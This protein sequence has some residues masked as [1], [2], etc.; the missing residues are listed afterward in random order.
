MSVALEFERVAKLGSAGNLL[1][2]QIRKVLADLMV[3]AGGEETLRA[4][5]INNFF[6]E[7]ITSKVARK[8]KGTSTRYGVIV[9]DFLASLGNQTVKPLTSLSAGDVER[10]L[11]YRTDMGLAPKT[12]VMDIKVIGSALNYARRQGIIT[13][14][15]AEALELPKGK[16]MERGTFT[17]VEVKLLIDAAVGEWKTL[18]LL[19]YFTGARLSDCCRMGWTDVD[20]GESM[21]T[22]TQSK[23]GE[24]VTM[25]IHEDL[26]AH[27]NK[28][29]ST[30]K[31]EEFLM[32]HTANLKSGGRKGLSETFKLI[33]RDAGLDAGKVKMVGVRQLS[34]RSF[35]ALR[36]SFNSAMA[37]A[38]VS[39]EVRMKLTGHKTESMNR[40]YT[41]HELEPLRNAI[42]KIPS[43]G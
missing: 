10:F 30:D 31:A 7:W 41:H 17:P 13:T 43:L 11:K 42:K 27:L 28:L 39:Q 18:I 40:G 29:A 37:N 25:P 26:L 1:E 24:K 35:H 32:P 22:Y 19:A 3:R 9:R 14:N 5:S 15:P 38:G 12:L 21:L 8:S 34:R 36:H 16:S 2:A 6:S 4:P 23:T 33:M 20:L